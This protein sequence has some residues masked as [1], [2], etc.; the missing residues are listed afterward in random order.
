MFKSDECHRELSIDVAIICDIVHILED[1]FLPYLGQQLLHRKRR[2]LLPE[3]QRAAVDYGK[4]MRRGDAEEPPEEAAT[5][6]VALCPIA[7]AS[8]RMPFGH[9]EDEAEESDV[10]LGHLEDEAEE[11]EDE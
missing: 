9:M 7:L 3:L 2:V 8:A 6:D 5:T 10:A 11:A 1:T 4:R